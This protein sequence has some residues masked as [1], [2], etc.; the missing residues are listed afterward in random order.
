MSNFLKQFEK[1]TGVKVP[2]S[3]PL[4]ET[5]SLLSAYSSLPSLSL[6]NL[7][8]TYGFYDRLKNAITLDKRSAKDI[9]LAT[10]EY[11]HA[12]DALMGREAQKIL[13]SKDKVTPAESNFASA[14]M[15]LIPGFSKV[16]RDEELNPNEYMYRNSSS[17][18][19]AFGVGNF[20]GGALANPTKPHVDATMATEAAILRDLLKRSTPKPALT[21]QDPLGLSIR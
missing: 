9:N 16:P 8:G 15:K 10:H 21:Y 3:S 7:T 20:G 17:E 18:L 6:Q 2:P 13:L 11:T 4:A 5:L 19:R 1:D 14:Y 12:L